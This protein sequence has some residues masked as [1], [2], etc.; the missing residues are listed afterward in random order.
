MKSSLLT[1]LAAG[2]MLASPARV[3]L[4]ASRPPPRPASPVNSY[5]RLS[6][7]SRANG[8]QL[9]W[10]KKD[11]TF[12]LSNQTSEINMAVNSREARINGVGVL[13]LFPAVYRDGNIYLHQLDLQNTFRPLLNPPKNRG[14][15]TITSICIDPGHGGRDPG[16]LVGMNQEKKHTLLLAQEVRDLLARKGLK[17]S[18]TR[19]SD[20]FIELSDRPAIARRRSADL[21]VSLHFNATGASAQ[22]V[23]GTEVYCLTPAGAPST[24]SRGEGS[25]GWSAGN[26]NNERNMFL[27]YQL[28]K[29]LTQGCGVEDRGVRRA[30]FVVLRDATMPAVLIESGFMTHPQEGKKI[31]SATYRRQLAQAIVDGLLRYKRAVEN[32]PNN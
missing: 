7:W 31:F 25:G 15:A 20:N 8:L 32:R 10:I 3:S 26:Q 5:A 28:Q 27:A 24:N 23:Q 2:L 9:Q 14:A 13:L 21:F 12:R 11:E 18:L 6:E 30:R 17:A 16:N 19:T 29:A 4:A 22:S 1:W